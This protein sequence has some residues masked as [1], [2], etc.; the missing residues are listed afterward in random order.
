VKKV[1]VQIHPSDLRL[2]KGDALALRYSIVNMPN[3][4][5][6]RWF[7][8]GVYQGGTKR[9]YPAVLIYDLDNQVIAVFKKF[10]GQFT[11]TCRLTLKEN[12]ELLR[13]GNFRTENSYN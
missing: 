3:K 10:T 8:N 4:E 13:T 11:T 1:F 7:D 6:I 9:G 12:D 5:N 2:R